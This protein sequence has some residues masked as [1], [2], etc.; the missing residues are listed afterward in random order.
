MQMMSNLWNSSTLVSIFWVKCHTVYTRKHSNKNKSCKDKITLQTECFVV[1]HILT[2][3]AAA[4]LRVTTARFF[5]RLSLTIL[6]VCVCVCLQRSWVSSV[7]KI[8]LIFRRL[9]DSNLYLPIV[10]TIFV[11]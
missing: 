5:A 8:R 10:E 9:V 1:M 7:H 4:A 2:M 11:Y 6:Y 3:S